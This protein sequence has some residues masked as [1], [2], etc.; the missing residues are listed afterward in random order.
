M[1][2]PLA[3]PTA[4]PDTSPVWPYVSQFLLGPSYVAH[5]EGWQHV[6]AARGFKLTLHPHLACTQVRD[7]ARELTLIGHALD[8]RAPDASNS[9]VLQ[10]LLARF[11]SRTEL[12]DATSGL[13]G[14]W[15]LIA[16]DGDDVFL[17]HDALGLRQAFYTEPA[18]VGVLWVMSQPGLAAEVA[19]LEPDPQALDFID[20]ETFRRVAEYRWPGGASTFVGLKHLL[21]NHWLDLRTGRSERYW[22]LAALE[23]LTPQAAVDRLHVLL[24]G[25]ICAAAARFDLALSLTA[26]ADSR[27]V[28][29]AARGITDQIQMMTVRQGRQPDRH[30]DIEVPARLLGRLGLTHTVVRATPTMTPE[31]GLQFK[32][33]VHFAHDHYGFDAEAILRQFGRRLATLTGSGAEVGRCPFRSKL[34][35]GDYVR[36]TSSTVAWLE[37][38]STHPFLVRH[39]EEWLESAGGQDFV[40]LLDLLEWEQDYGNWLA[41]VQQEFDVAWRDIFTPFNCREVLTTLLGV[42]ERYRRARDFILWRMYI[43]KA[44]P[45]LLA[46]P[47]NPQKVVTRLGQLVTNVKAIRNYWKFAR[48]QR[49]VSAGQL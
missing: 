9:D 47:I 26:G 44:W 38:G 30:P 18:R 19:A 37:Y 41:M 21:P 17:F 11:R 7:G 4:L 20:T 42:P 8:A 5:L 10:A 32:R 6:A 39:F 49:K 46:E 28:L 40:K 45:E 29:A 12:V 24:P 25:Q 1:R 22:P 15:L 16:A 27:V 23:T 2:A 31:F 48:R 43:E 14:R 33:N 3:S 34:P 35:H 36:Y 13:G